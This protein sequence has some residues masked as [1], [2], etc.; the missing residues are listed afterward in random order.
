MLYQIIPARA[1]FPNV[2]DE[3]PHDVQ[4]MIA[5]KDKPL[6]RHGFLRSINILLLFFSDFQ[7]DELLNDVH[8]TVL[9]QNLFP[10]V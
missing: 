10:Y 7:T 8:H 6:P 2:S 1:V 5:G 4:L 9:V 3:L